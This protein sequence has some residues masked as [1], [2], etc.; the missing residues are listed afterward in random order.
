MG[1]SG[2]RQWYGGP[3]DPVFADNTCNFSYLKQLLLSI[4]PS[5]PV[6]EN[7]PVFSGCPLQRIPK[8]STT[9]GVSAVTWGVIAW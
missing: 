9:I 5:R 7:R 4:T 3:A 2:K 6:P 1:W 8:M